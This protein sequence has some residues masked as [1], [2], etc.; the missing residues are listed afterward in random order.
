MQVD[1]DSQKLVV[2]TINLVIQALELGDCNDLGDAKS[3]CKGR[4]GLVQ[5]TTILVLQ[6]KQ[7]DQALLRNEERRSAG[8]LKIG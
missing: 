3:T 5:T 1:H 2:N 6:E 8:A 4:L 7:L